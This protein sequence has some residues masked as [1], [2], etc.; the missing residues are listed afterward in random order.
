[1]LKKTAFFFVIL[2]SFMHVFCCGLPLLLSLTSLAAMLGLSSVK[3]MHVSWFVGSMQVNI[4][5]FSGLVLAGS[6]VA[7]WIGNRLDCH[8]DG[9]CHHKPCDK[10]KS[11]S[12]WF[13]I[14]AVCLYVV[15]VVIFFIT[16]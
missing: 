8:T 14:A 16:R 9:H 7:Q 11:L 15:N 12:G 5:I 10:K 6:C 4:L 13:L 3:I 2:S 1:M